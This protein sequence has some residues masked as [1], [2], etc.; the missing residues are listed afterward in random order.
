MTGSELAQRAPRFGHEVL[1]LSHAELD[2]S[3]SRRVEQRIAGFRPNVVINAA[4]YTAV[5]RAES[6]PQH[7]AAVNSIGAGNVA[8][9]ARQGSAGIIHISTDYVFDGKSNAPYKPDDPP[10]P[11]SVYGRTKLDGENAVRQANE[12]HCIV[13]TSWVFSRTGTNFLQTMLRLGDERTEIPVVNDQRGRPTYAG[14][15]ADALLTAAARLE[16]SSLA[17]GTYHFANAGE[18]TWFE[19]ARTIFELTRGNSAAVV[20]I[21]TADYPTAA[22]RPRYSVLDTTNFT[23]RFGIEPRPWRDS[24]GEVL[25]QR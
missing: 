22:V 4:G 25:S 19:F 7:A 15:L 24:L 6:E 20:P 10:A 13:R 16:E 14:D 12:N 8:R 3:D 23:Q 21:A 9:A 18:T 1:A 5:D 2:I 17:R 11:R